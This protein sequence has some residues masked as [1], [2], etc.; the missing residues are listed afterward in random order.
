MKK[1][2]ALLL[3]L[4]MTV[5]MITACGGGGNDKEYDGKLVVATSPDFP[6][7]ENLEGGK[8]VGIEIDLIKL[9]CEELNYELVIESVAFDSIVTGVETGKYDCGVAGITVDE[10]RAE[11]VLFTTPYC[12]AAQCI[13]V[14]ADSAIASK[15]DLDGKTISVQSATTAES[16]CLKNNYSV[17][18]YEANADAKLA[19][20]TGK[21]DAWVVDDLTAAEMCKND[22]NVK[23]LEDRMTSEP[24]AFAFN[25]EDEELVEKIN[26]ILERLMADGTVEALFEQYGAIYTAPELEDNGGSEDDTKTI[27][28]A[29]SPDFPPFENLEGGEIVGIEVELVK[30]ICA[31][32]GYNYTFESIAF[33]SVVPG[34]ATGKY[35]MGMS[36]ISVTPDREKSVLFTTPYC[37]AA[38][39]IVVTA[40]SEITCKADLDGKTISVQSG[41][42][43]EDFCLENGYTVKSYEANADAKLALTTGKVDAW[44][45]DDLT[46]AEMCKGDASVKILS[47]NMTTEPYAFAFNFADEA[48]VE[49]FNAALEELIADGTVA[50]LFEQFD[51][52]YTAPT[53]E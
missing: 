16:Y 3:C 48:L 42:T 6:P 30:L 31:K 15:A 8:I 37:L 35:T 28:I 27:T 9:I 41:T 17:D 7:F 19:L 24:Y 38:Q 10:D 13:V 21:V 36:G 12:L 29:T 5:G 45:V 39:C 20:T 34:I 25:F 32:L 18:S 47:E 4:L 50:A 33:E 46:A 52:P 11:S 14:A 2:I 53:E 1:I 44:V 40:D 23:I 22:S 49:E 43:A 26:V 51:A